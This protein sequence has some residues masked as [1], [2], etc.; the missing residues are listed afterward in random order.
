MYTKPLSL[1]AEFTANDIWFD[2]SNFLFVLLSHFSKVKSIRTTGRH[3]NHMI[4][5]KT[6]KAF[7]SCARQS[8]CESFSMQADGSMLLLKDGTHHKPRQQLYIQR[9]PPTEGTHR[10]LHSNQTAGKHTCHP[11]E[12]QTNKTK[13]F[14]QVNII[15]VFQIL[16]SIEKSVQVL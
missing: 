4:Q 6:I 16:L 9:M 8:T 14:F 13:C 10:S 12:R 5:N 11:A 7:I 15:F 2:Y 3:I 1:M